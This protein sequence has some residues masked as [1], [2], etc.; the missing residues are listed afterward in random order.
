MNN[1]IEKYKEN[2]KR[3]D[4]LSI[5]IAE[6]AIEYFQISYN[7]DS[8]IIEG[9]DFNRYSEKDRSYIKRFKGIILEIFENRCA[10]CGGNRGIESDHFFI[11]KVH[12]GSFGLKTHHGKIVN[13]AIPLCESCNRSK[14]SK[15]YKK[16]EERIVSQIIAKNEILTK[17]IDSELREH[18]NPPRS[19]PQHY[20]K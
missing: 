2:L 5:E 4:E 15:S 9:Q 6:S 18:P 7:K 10:I 13:N 1:S 20:Y 17:R 16:L 3:I 12:G 8:F 11:P 14:G 19:N